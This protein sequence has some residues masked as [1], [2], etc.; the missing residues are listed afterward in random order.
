MNTKVVVAWAEIDSS[1]TIIGV[2]VERDDGPFKWI[3]LYATSLALQERRQ[4]Q[5]RG[6]IDNDLAELYAGRD[7][8]RRA[9][10]IAAG[11]ASDT[12]GSTVIREDNAPVPAAPD[13]GKLTVMSVTDAQAGTRVPAAPEPT[14]RRLRY[15]GASDEQ[16]DY[17]GNDDP[18]K[19]L[20]IGNIYTL[21]RE[22]VGDF[23]TDIYLTAFP[24]LR[25]NSVC[26]ESAI[27]PS[28]SKES[29][30]PPMDSLAEGF[31]NPETLLNSR[32]WLTKAVTKCGAKV[33]GG[34]CGCGQADIDIL[35]EGC[36]FNVSIRPI[37][38]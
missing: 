20:T 6:K 11:Q 28:P 35:L 31:G 13:N 2:S 37:I 9:A 3:P 19:V 21:L 7:K 32:D 30:V 25:F 27:E 12:L 4:G 5:R 1:G 38:K 34:G 33:T 16:V 8:D 10:P 18:R 22:D 24:K 15:I 14:P 23:H 36:K 26:F 17:R 29:K